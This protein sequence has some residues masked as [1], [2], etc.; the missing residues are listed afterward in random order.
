VV[1]EGKDPSLVVVLAEIVPKG[2]KRPFTKGK[3]PSLVPRR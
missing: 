2:K 3:V 1:V